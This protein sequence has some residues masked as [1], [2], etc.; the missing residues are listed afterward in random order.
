MADIS[1]SGQ[2]VSKLDLIS[3]NIYRYPSQA[4]GGK[5]TFSVPLDPAGSALFAIS[6]KKPNEPEWVVKTGRE[7]ILQTI[8][9]PIAERKSDNVLMINYLDL[10]T[11]NSEKKE[12]YFMN[13]LESLFRENG[14]SIGNPWQHKIQYR[15][16]YLELDTLFTADSWFEATYHFDIDTSLGLREM[17]KMRAVVERPGLWTV[18]INGT[19]LD[20]IAGSYWIDR[21][22]PLYAIGEHLQYGK[23]TLTLKAPRMHIL[24]E[25]MPVY[26]LGDFL[27]TPAERGFKI[28]GGEITGTGSWRSKGLPFYS[29]KVGY[30]QKYM[31]EKNP[32]A[33]C[34]VRLNHWNGTVAG[35]LVNGAEAGVIAWPPYELDITNMVKEGENQI[36]VEVTGSLK[37]TFGFFYQDN[38]SWIFGPHAW[39]YAPEK[40]PDASGYFLMDYGLMQPFDLMVVN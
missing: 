25:V 7:T 30:T 28:S 4:Q 23:N 14:V 9:G 27:V 32:E 22:F 6:N 29:Q 36:T 17:E 31:L 21:D 8:D 33:I 39:N 34:K 15:Q 3:G 20:K 40:A 10:K 12:I 5:V 16:N 37:N 24:A 38:K 26:I 13:A 11:A 18:N 19:R 1:V 2:F 35:V